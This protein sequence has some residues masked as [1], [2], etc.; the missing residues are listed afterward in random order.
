M[1]TTAHH[2]PTELGIAL[3]I[4]LVIGI[5]VILFSSNI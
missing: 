4:L 3:W 5:I 2:T 1:G